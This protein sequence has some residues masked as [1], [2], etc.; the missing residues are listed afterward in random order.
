MRFLIISVVTATLF[1]FHRND[2]RDGGRSGV[3]GRND[4]HTFC[5]GDVEVGD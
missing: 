5:E 1:I 4:S 2:A 3:G